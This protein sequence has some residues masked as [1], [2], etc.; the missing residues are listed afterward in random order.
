MKES[1]DI[2]RGTWG[3]ALQGLVDK[4]KPNLYDE[5]IEL[6]CILREEIYHRII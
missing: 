5:L 3:D 2:F 6:N 1:K 4:F